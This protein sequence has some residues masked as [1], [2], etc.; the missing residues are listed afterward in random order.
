MCG[1][2][3]TM[4]HHFSGGMMMKWEHYSFIKVGGKYVATVR[5]VV[6]S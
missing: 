3:G 6:L 4:W 1:T 5:P 2:I